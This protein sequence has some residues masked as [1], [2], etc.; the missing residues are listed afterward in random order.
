MK[1]CACEVCDAD[2][3]LHYQQLWPSSLMAIQCKKYE[4][5]HK[6][7]CKYGL[8]IQAVAQVATHHAC[9]HARA[10][11]LQKLKGYFNP[12]L[13]YLSCSIHEDAVH[14]HRNTIMECAFPNFK[15]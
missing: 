12:I 15:L 14:D 1:W 4:S 9:M 2:A 10:H 3:S 6:S 13:G 11:T 7:Y 8:D 5:D